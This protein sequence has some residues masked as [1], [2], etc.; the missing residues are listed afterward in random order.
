MNKSGYQLPVAQHSSDLGKNTNEIQNAI[1]DICPVCDKY[2]K[3]GVQCGYSQSWFHFK[4]EDTTEEQV[5]KEYPAEQQYIYMQDWHQTFVNTLQF[6]YQ[7]K[8]EINK[9]TKRK[10]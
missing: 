8:I 1:R 7:K 5:S 2:D 4:C 3:T 10:V 9:K 6:Q